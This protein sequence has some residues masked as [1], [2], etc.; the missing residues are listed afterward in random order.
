M[1]NLKQPCSFKHPG[2][3]KKAVGTVTSI[4]SIQCYQYWVHWHASHKHRTQITQMTTLLMTPTRR[5]L[6]L[7]FQRKVRT[8]WSGER[9]SQI[10]QYCSIFH[11]V[12]GYY[13]ARHLSMQV[14]LDSLRNLMQFSK[15]QSW[16]VQEYICIW[17]R[18]IT[19]F[20]LILFAMPTIK[21]TMSHMVKHLWLQAV[22]YV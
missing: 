2:S 13:L 12:M 5:V 8:W 17:W 3:R 9:M 4:K 1:R 6:Y 16:A 14:V 19:W 21:I 22:P 7:A 20:Q 10:T 15:T 11:M 18:I